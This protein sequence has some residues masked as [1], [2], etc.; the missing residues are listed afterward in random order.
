[1][2]TLLNSHFSSDL[3]P[4][5]LLNRILLHCGVATFP[6]EQDMSAPFTCDFQELYL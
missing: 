5:F 4:L 2:P 1:M 6:S 3:N